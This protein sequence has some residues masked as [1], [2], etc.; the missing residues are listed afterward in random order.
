MLRTIL[1]LLATLAFYLFI[2]H[3]F[4][5]SYKVP[6]GS[7]MPAIQIGDVVLANKW[8]YKL[9]DP[10]R[11]DII[12][13]IYPKDE[14]LDYIKRLIGLPGD[15]F[16]IKNQIVYI[17]NTPLN[18]PYTI[19]SEP[20]LEGEASRPRDNFGPIRIPLGNYFVMG[21]NREYSRDSRYF[22][23]VQRDKIFG[24]ADRIV[25]SIDENGEERPD[26]S[27]VPFPEIQY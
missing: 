27:W 15:K 21:D 1:A 6:A 13:F 7:M 3:N 20:V 22:G 5:Q 12:L 2:R 23:L 9:E 19:H 17:N 14:N 8:L 24:K 4:Y 11:G 16:E 18:E 26:R 25:N 10:R